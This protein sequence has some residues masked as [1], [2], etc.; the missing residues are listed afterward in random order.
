MRKN[1]NSLLQKKNLKP[2]ERI[3]L[4]IANQ[5]AIEKGK[6]SILTEADE[7]ALSEG[8]IPNNDEAIEYN[9]YNEGWRLTGFMELDAYT[10]YLKAENSFFK[11]K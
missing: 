1:I 10:T 6:K 5:I 9:R 8:W 4:L 3:L 7:Y 11:S 2:K